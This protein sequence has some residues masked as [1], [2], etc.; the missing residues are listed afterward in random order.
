MEPLTI[1]IETN[2]R[3]LSSAYSG[4]QR[5]TTV[6]DEGTSLV[7]TGMLV[8]KGGGP[9]ILSDA[10]TFIANSAAS[11][12]LGLLGAWLYDKVKDRPK[13]TRLLI[14]RKVVTEITPEGIRRVLKEE[15]EG[16]ANYD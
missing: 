10:L 1:T 8:R 4:M 12:D 7:Y 16:P 6:L 15:I 5:N 9:D 3:S 13:E 2:D 14:R 11:L